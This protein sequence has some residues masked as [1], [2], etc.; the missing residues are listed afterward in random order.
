[1][2]EPTFKSVSSDSNAGIFLYPSMLNFVRVFT[3]IV[4]PSK[5][6]KDGAVRSSYL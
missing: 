4:M 5:F 2:A 3:S 1:M 6:A